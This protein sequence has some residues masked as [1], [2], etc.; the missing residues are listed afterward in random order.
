MSVKNSNAI[1]STT[2]IARTRSYCWIFTWLP[3]IPKTKETLQQLLVG[4]RRLSPTNKQTISRPLLFV[5]H[6]IWRSFTLIIGAKKRECAILLL[7]TWTFGANCQRSQTL[8][9]LQRKEVARL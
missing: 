4:C 1:I 3:T 7:L 9:V 8:Y 5:L 2:A 6:P